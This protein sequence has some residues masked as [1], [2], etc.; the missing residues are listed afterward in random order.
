MQQFNSLEEF[1]K[2]FP[3]LVKEIKGS[4]IPGHTEA[5]KTSRLTNIVEALLGPT[6]GEKAIQAFKDIVASGMTA[7]QYLDVCKAMSVN[8]VILPTES[9]NRELVLIQNAINQARNL[10]REGKNEN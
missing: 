6:F 1:E 5:S 2:A 3:K 10:M 9:K 7:S 8:P 4:V